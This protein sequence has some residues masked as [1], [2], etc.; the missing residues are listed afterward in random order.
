MKDKKFYFSKSTEVSANLFYF[1]MFFFLSF[2]VV[3]LSRLSLLNNHISWDILHLYN[4]VTPI[5]DSVTF[6]NL[7]KAG[8][9]SR[10][11]VLKKQ[12]TLLSV[13]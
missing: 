12:Y 11:I 8:M 5:I 7:K 6:F 1:S 2:Y 4:I 13:L 3:R 9:A 10:N